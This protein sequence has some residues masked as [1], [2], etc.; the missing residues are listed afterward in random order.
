[1]PQC[2]PS[3][4]I[5]KKENKQIKKKGDGTAKKERSNR[6]IIQRKVGNTPQLQ[7]WLPRKKR[8]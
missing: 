5:K 2:T 4:T 3:T 1:M 7:P 8:N 6:K